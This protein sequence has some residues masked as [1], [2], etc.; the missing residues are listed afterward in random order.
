MAVAASLLML[1][2]CSNDNVA[3]DKDL[4]DMPIFIP[5][6]SEVEILLGT[7][8]GN[9][10]QVA[11]R[12]ALEND[13]DMESIGVFCLAREKQNINE[14]A[15]DITWFSGT[16]EDWSGCIMKKVEARKEGGNV[17]WC[18]DTKH[19]YYPISQFYCYDFFGYYPYVEDS[20]VRME[21]NRVEVTYLLDGKTD[22]IWGRATSD[23]KYA[24]S[25]AYFRQ[26]GNEE[27]F[28]ELELKHV[29]ARLKFQVVPG[30]QVENG[31]IVSPAMADFAVA[32]VMLID[33]PETAVLT[34]AD[35]DRMS[36][37]DDTNCIVAAMGLTDY[38]LCKEDGSP[39]DTTMVGMDM[40]MTTSLG[41]SML[42]MPAKEYIVRVYLVNVKTGDEFVTEHPLKLTNA[43]SFRPGYTYTV[44][45]TAHEPKEV[46]LQA[47]LHP[48]TDAEDN[49]SVD[50]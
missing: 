34:V 23:E 9:G 27:T 41:E 21:Q 24:Y 37:L 3:L 29:M 10:V 5:G 12:S 8:G 26:P 7:M 30:P 40:N 35:Y 1:P 50:L 39:M 49:P 15:Y 32:K 13:A 16:D 25:A 6:N 47:K 22:I 42:V 14:S 2:G 36:T 28:P 20:D 17:S 4:S 46:Q 18:D 11:K 45:I 19:Y 48:W 31:D 44:T 33:E 38:E 43:N